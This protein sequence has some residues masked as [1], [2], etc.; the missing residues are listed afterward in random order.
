MNIRLNL[1]DDDIAF[2]FG[3]HRTTVSCNFHKVLDVM[4]V[5]TSHLIKWPTREILYET[6][7]D[8][9]SRSAVLLN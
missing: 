5:Q 3:V 8:V 6:Q 4:A 9:F 1:F 2:C 7:P